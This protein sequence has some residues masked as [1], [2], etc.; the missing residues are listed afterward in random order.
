VSGKGSSPGKIGQQKGTVRVAAGGVL[1]GPKKPQAN[2][3]GMTR[4]SLKRGNRGGLGGFGGEVGGAWAGE[5]GGGGGVGG[6]GGGFFEG[7]EGGGGGGGG[8][9]GRVVKTGKISDGE[10]FHNTAKPGLNKKMEPHALT[11]KQRYLRTKIHKKEERT[12]KARRKL[13]AEKQGGRI[14]INTDDGGKTAWV[15]PTDKR[16][17]VKI[18]VMGQEGCD[19]A[20]A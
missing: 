8:G 11:Q 16:R 1:D 20:S 12:G 7:G 19:G 6:G 5:E 14:H 17:K 4:K 18:R 9:G 2:A 10:E 3:E 15:V 13:K